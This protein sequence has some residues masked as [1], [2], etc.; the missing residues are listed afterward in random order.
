MTRAFNR[1]DFATVSDALILE[2][3][4]IYIW[5]IS[6]KT[7]MEKEIDQEIVCSLV[8]PKYSAFLRSI[9]VFASLPVN[10]GK[11]SESPFQYHPNLYC[12]YS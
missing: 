11:L 1:T 8:V 5:N 6:V 12:L 2:Y 4:E 3:I 10:C 9:L 7:E